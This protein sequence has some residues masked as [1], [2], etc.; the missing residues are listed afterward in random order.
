MH[1]TSSKLKTSVPQRTPPMKWKDNPENGRNYSQIMYLVKKKKKK[2]QEPG[3]LLTLIQKK[4]RSLEMF[5]HQLMHQNYF[6]IKTVS[7]NV[8]WWLLLW[9][10]LL[11]SY[12]EQILFPDKITHFSTFCHPMEGNWRPSNQR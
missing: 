1:W 2:K 4:K 10:F 12:Q 6:L 8:F 7:K 9:L 11:L 5:K 3:S